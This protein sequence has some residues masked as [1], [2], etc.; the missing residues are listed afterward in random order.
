MKEIIRAA[1]KI[2]ATLP[3]TFQGEWLMVIMDTAAYKEM[4]E[5]DKDEAREHL[6]MLIENK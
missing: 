5:A 6:Q 3:E 1:N 2:M 4:S